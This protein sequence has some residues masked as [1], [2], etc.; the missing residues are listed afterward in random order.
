MAEGLTSHFRGDEFA[1]YSA[2]TNPHALNPYA[3]KVMAEI[4]IDISQHTSKH[5]E[6]FKDTEFDYVVTVCDNAQERCPIWLDGGISM[7]HSFNDPAVLEVTAKSE[8]DLLSHYRRVRDEIRSFIE[9]FP[10]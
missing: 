2:G 1:A 3:I 10:F 9:H 7:H 8:E 5:V 4:G 6:V